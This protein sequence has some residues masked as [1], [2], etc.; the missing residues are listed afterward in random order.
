MTHQVALVIKNPP[1]DAGDLRDM[2]LTPGGGHGNPLQYSCLENPMDR[3][4]WWTTGHRVTKSGHDCRDFVGTCDLSWRVFCVNVRG[5]CILLSNGMSYKCEM[6]QDDKRI[7]CDTDVKGANDVGSVVPVSLLDAGSL[8]TFSWQKRTASVRQVCPP[9][10]LLLLCSCVCTQV[11][12]VVTHKP[13]RLCS[14]F[15]SFFPFY[16]RG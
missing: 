9:A 7:K 6:F 8:Q 5:E 10:L 3:G 11:S 14:V 4:A 2:G 16:P 1:T 12:P 15:S 13:W